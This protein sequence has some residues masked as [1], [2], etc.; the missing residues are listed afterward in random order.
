M[1]LSRASLGAASVGCRS[2]ASSLHSSS[3]SSLRLLSTSSSPE[4]VVDLLPAF[5][6]E[7]ANPSRIAV[8]RMSRHAS[9]NA[10]G[11][12]MLAE[13]S[14][15]VKTTLPSDPTLRA[16]ILTSSVERVF[17]AGADLKER[18][19]MSQ[20][21]AGLFVS[22]LRSTFSD[23]ANLPLPVIAS[24]EGAA[25]GGGLE[26]ALCCDFLVAGSSATFGLPETSLAIIPG[27]GGTQRLPRRIGAA[28]AKELIFTGRKVS[29]AEAMDYGLA[30]HVVKEGGA[31]EKAWEIAL[32]IA[33]NGPVGVRS[34]K[35]A[36]DV[37]MEVD[38]AS[39]MEVEKVCYAQTIPTKDRL[40]GLAAFAEKRKP[41]YK[42]E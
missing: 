31:F 15:A 25:L 1:F 30:Q 41:I 14:T 29:A 26:I 35:K 39:G 13:L 28:R 4:L 20:I 37:G 24:V 5:P 10:L 22:S 6:S 2:I 17:C 3:V 16:V 19:T 42:G 18:K 9:K 34:A 8:L 21:E 40:E 23:V 36:V 32:L 38:L 12:Q 33:R 11:R 27:A 7:P